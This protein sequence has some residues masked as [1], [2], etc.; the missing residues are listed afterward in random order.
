MQT[1]WF[2]H[3]AHAWADL[4]L[5]SCH[6]HSP[7]C[8]M[9]HWSACQNGNALLVPWFSCTFLSWCWTSE[10]SPT[11][12][13]LIPIARR[14]N[15]AVWQDGGKC[16]VA[17]TRCT[18]LSQKCSVA[19]GNP[20]RLGIIKK[21]PEI[22]TLDQ[23]K[24]CRYRRLQ[25]AISFVSSFASQLRFQVLQVSWIVFDDV[26]HLIAEATPATAP[27]CSKPFQGLRTFRGTLFDSSCLGS[28]HVT[29]EPSARIAAGAISLA[30][31]AIDIPP[32]TSV[33]KSHHKV[34]TSETSKCVAGSLNIAALSSADLGL[35]TTHPSPWISKCTGCSLDLLHTLGSPCYTPMSAL[36]QLPRS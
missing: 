22:N 3:S 6:R 12:T 29:T 33:M 24:S 30:V 2:E 11:F 18:Q 21:W 27:K 8:P 15:R 20:T 31:H 23:A 17:P 19:P 28:P 16:P 7:C 35:L 9:H 25:P 36:R 32:A 5:Q 34:I 1:S 26:E 14:H 4:G 13:N 10:L